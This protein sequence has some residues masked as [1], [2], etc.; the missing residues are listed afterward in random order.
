MAFKRLFALAQF[1]GLLTYFVLP[2]AF[3]ALGLAEASSRAVSYAVAALLGY[4]ASVV[5]YGRYGLR[6]ETEGV[7]WSG[8]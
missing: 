6:Y 7:L 1:Y 8:A 5:L 2:V 3:R 4:V